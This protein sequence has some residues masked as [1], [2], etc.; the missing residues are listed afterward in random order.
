[1]AVPAGN[2]DNQA[3]SWTKLGNLV[4]TYYRYPSFA[5]NVPT[6]TAQVFEF[7]GGAMAINTPSKS[8][9]I[10]S[11][12]F[13]AEANCGVCN[14]IRG[15]RIKIK[16]DGVSTLVFSIEVMPN[17]VEQTTLSNYFFDVLG[18]NHTITWELDLINN[19]YPVTYAS[20]SNVTVMVLPID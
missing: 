17:G 20:I 10:I 6:G 8:R 18:G 15:G 19:S 14:I 3:T 12:M 1:M 16:V 9:L 7:G 2:G 4:Q 13:Y 5:A 11:A